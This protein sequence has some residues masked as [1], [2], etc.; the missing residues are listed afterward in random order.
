MPPDVRLRSGI[1]V[2]FAGGETVV[3][4]GSSDAAP[5]VVSHAHGDHLVGGT[6]GI[7]ASALTAELASV[8]QEKAPPAVVDHPA[9]SLFNAG[10]VAGSRAALLTD[11]DTGHRTLYT[12]DCCTRDRFYLDGFDPVDADSLIVETTYGHPRYAF[13]PTDEVVSAILDWLAET[14]DTVVV[15]FG[16]ALGRAQKLLWILSRSARSRVFVTDAIARLNAVIERRMDVSFDAR[17]YTGDVDLEAGDALVVPMQTT[18]LSWL[19]SLLETHEA[20]AAGF[21]GWAAD[22]SFVYRRGLDEGFV[23]SDHCDFEELVGVVRAVDPETVY[24]H[25][26]FAEEFARHLTSE[27]GYE[28]RALKRNQSTLGNF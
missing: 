25:H 9:V 6:D 8:R 18:R 23:L 12:G 19:Q 14:M 24:T 22:Q 5:P 16:Y 26:G 17:P 7:V 27:Y 1:E 28:T 3:L 4:D 2:A 11:P 13:P 10:H 21:S 20:V 15:L